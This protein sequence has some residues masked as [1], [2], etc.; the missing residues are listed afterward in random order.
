MNYLPKN[1]AMQEKAILGFCVATFTLPLK[2]S[3]RNG[4]MLVIPKNNNSFLWMIM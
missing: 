4:K 3:G 1:E 2:S